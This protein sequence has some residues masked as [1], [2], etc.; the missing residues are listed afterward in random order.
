VISSRRRTAHGLGRAGAC[1]TPETLGLF[2][3]IHGD[4][5]LV[6]KAERLG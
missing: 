2:I 5:Q 3:G 4:Y 6:I 1:R